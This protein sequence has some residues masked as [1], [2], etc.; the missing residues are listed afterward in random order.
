VK[1][2]AFLGNGG[3]IIEKENAR[4]WKRENQQKAKS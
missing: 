1:S 2:K 3:A 4:A